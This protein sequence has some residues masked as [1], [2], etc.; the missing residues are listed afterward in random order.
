MVILNTLHRI[1]EAVNQAPEFDAALRT[2]VARVKA[3]LATDVCSI[4]IADYT[5]EE[6]VLAASDGLPMQAG[7]RV[8]L[9]F[10]EGLISLAAQREEPLNYA[11]ASQHPSFKWVEDVD[12]ERFNA[13]LVAPIIHQRR[14]LG[15]L[16]VQQSEARAFSADEESFVV[17]LAAQLAAVIA[18][19]EAKGLLADHSAPWLRSLRALPG[20]SGVAIGP[21][22]IG[23]PAARLSAVV[24]RKTDKPW[25]HIRLFRKAVMQTRRELQQL[26][27][28]VAGYVAEDTLAIF[29]V[30]QG[31]LDAAS[32]GDAVENRIREGWMVQTAVK[33]TVDEYVSQFEDLDDPYLKER[34]VDV[35]DLGQRILSHLQQRNAQNRV[36]PDHCILV[37]EEVTA[38]MLAEIPRE[39]LQGIVSLRGSANSHAAIMARS[40]GVP[41]VLGIED[42]PL[43]YLEGQFLIV[44]G[45]SG[46][47]FVNPGEQVIDEYQQLQR[48]EEELA[49]QVARDSAQPAETKDGI[50]VSL[51]MNAGLNIEH[52]KERRGDFDGIGLYRTE[53][54]FM[55]RERFPTETEQREL[56]ARVLEAFAGQPVVMRT[57]DVGGDKPL[58]YFPLHEDNPFLGW[59]GIRLTLDHPEIFLV[60]ARA[61]LAANIDHGNLNVLLPMIST[62]EEVEEAAR[63]L[64]QAY[65]EVR[66]ELVQYHP[67]KTLA[68]P[69]L[70]VMIEVPGVLY[71]L[72]AIAAKVDFFSVGTNDLTQYLLAVDRNNPRVASLY[73]PYHPAVLR[74]LQQIIDTCQAANKPVSVCGEFAG[75]PGGALLLVAMGYRQL[76]MSANNIAKIKWIIRNVHGATLQVLLTQAFNA[77]H[78]SQ[79]HRVVN[80]KLESLGMGGFIRAGK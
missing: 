68:R 75:E 4:Y 49:E 27:Q 77:K 44:D 58:P 56:Y 30:Y 66:N 1:V 34:A 46:E 29:D 8:A 62:L 69:R 6:F 63:L 64:N 11:T 73:D 65:F 79:V 9:K 57:L 17:T 35:R 40:M 16:A 60:Q 22:F 31:M 10:G 59:R 45:Y 76:S 36:I 78:P 23:K 50:R 48:E 61:M 33:L 5:N 13:M 71:Q 52:G 72:D 39:K 12:D 47:L 70:G 3:A 51:Q 67:G 38:S 41:A 7:E 80:S 19:A 54:P 14:V 28:Q 37:A 20:S 55:M 2:M 18:H 24:P 15:V 32:L 26:A 21:A 74:A 25:R 42:V 53:I 43:Q